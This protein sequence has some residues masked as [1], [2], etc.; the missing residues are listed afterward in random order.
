MM[1]TLV[2]E[3]DELLGDG[4]CAGLGQLGFTVDWVR[5]GETA[6]R[7]LEA[8]D[9]DVA[10]VDIGL[11]QRS[12]ISVL[13]ICRESGNAVPILMLTARDLV[14]DKV[15]CLDSG[16]D[17]YLVKPFDIDELAA[18]L[19]AIVRRREG[20]STSEIVHGHLVVDPAAR[21][22]T[23]RGRPVS[24][25]RR[26]FA[27]LHA[28]LAAAGKVVSREQLERT[29]YGW[30]EEIESN[31]VQV[32]VHHLRKKLGS[33]LIETVRGVGYVIRGTS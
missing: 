32:H 5:D 23:V 19:R 6:T 15:L 4:I 29:L 33:A 10:V 1:R 27:I 20:R 31:A 28:L 17:D 26:E 16:A 24:V 2:V 7:V 3:D 8:D 11:P 12:G 22:V 30:D 21:T 25:S 9:F 18:R 13:R 14:G